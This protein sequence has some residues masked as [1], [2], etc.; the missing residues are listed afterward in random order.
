MSSDSNGY[1]R[2]HTL[3]KCI[4]QQRP[5]HRVGQRYAS[6]EKE[7]EEEEIKGEIEEEIEREEEITEGERGRDRE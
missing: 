7:R 6:R 1:N 5:L 2:L 3:C 4:F